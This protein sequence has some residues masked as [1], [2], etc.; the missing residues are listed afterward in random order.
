ME[1][2]YSEENNLI[3]REEYELSVS[4]IIFLRKTIAFLRAEILASYEDRGANSEVSAIYWLKPFIQMTGGEIFDNRD[5]DSD[6]E[7][8]KEVDV[9]VLL[10][11]EIQYIVYLN[12]TRVLIV[13]EDA[14]DKEEYYGSPRSFRK[15]LYYLLQIAR[16]QLENLQSSID[17]LIGSETNE[18]SQ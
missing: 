11:Q 3:S 17:F 6:S 7:F 13:G 5:F 16:I 9:F 18:I 14:T 12:G 15:F 1:G 2:S 8:R 4:A 10:K